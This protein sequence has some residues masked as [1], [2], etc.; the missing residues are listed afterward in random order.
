M[1]QSELVKKYMAKNL[2]T[3]TPEMSIAD[4]MSIILKNKISGAPVVDNNKQ[5]VGMLSESDCIRTV[6]DG[7]YN[8]LPGGNG[9][10]GDYMSRKVTTIEAHK[11]IVELATKFI[12]TPYRRFPVVDRGKLVGQ[13]SISDVLR[14]I[15][16]NK[17]HINHTPSSW[18]IREPQDKG[19]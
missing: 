16:K 7:P 6:L 10:V 13:V 2:I 4:A 17:P 11:T 5:L 15:V 14:A 19:A 3:F 12:N 8:N 18:K 1:D 9:T